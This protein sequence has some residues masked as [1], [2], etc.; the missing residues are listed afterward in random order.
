MKTTVQNAVCV[1]IAFVCIKSQGYNLQSK[2][3]VYSPVL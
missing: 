2:Q 1:Y 3:P